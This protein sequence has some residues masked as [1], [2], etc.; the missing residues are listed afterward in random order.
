MPIGPYFSIEDDTYCYP[1]SNVLR[2]KLGITD[3]NKLAS[4]EGIITVIKMDE[5]DKNPIK[6]RFESERC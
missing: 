5:L 2:N 3:Y 4:I 1:D 6:G